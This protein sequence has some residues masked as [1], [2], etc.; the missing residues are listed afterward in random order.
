MSTRQPVI[1]TSTL[2][3][4]STSESK[5]IGQL[6]LLPTYGYTS[7]FSS[8]SNFLTTKNATLEDYTS[9]KNG[10]NSLPILLMIFAV[11]IICLFIYFRYSIK[12]SFQKLKKESKRQQPSIPE[13]KK[14]EQKKNNKV[15]QKNEDEKNLKI[16][17]IPRNTDLSRFSVKKSD[18]HTTQ[19]LDCDDECKFEISLNYF[20]TAK[21]IPLKPSFSHTTQQL[22]DGPEDSVF[23]IDEYNKH[24]KPNIFFEK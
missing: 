8:T 13:R 11:V 9:G 14:L 23:D 4:T 10:F 6:S 5:F 21:K 16:N 18:S 22:N 19:Q 3:S 12:N 20:D 24:L 7:L 2:I 17:L 1:L 15:K